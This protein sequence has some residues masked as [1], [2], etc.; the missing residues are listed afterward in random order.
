MSRRVALPFLIY[1]IIFFSIGGYEK[2]SG[3]SIVFMISIISL[4]LIYVFQ[5]QIDMTWWKRHPPLLSPKLK[6]WLL[7][8]SAYFKQLDPVEQDRFER[9]L[10]LFIKDKTFTLKL[11]K[12]YEVEED[13]KAVIGHEF[14]RLTMQ[15]EDF[16]YEHYDQFIIY[17]HPF[18]S[19]TIRLLHSAETYYDDGVVILSR[20]QVINGFVKPLEYVNVAMLMAVAC[21]IRLYPR[22]D[23]PP[24]MDYSPEEIAEG[25]EILLQPI[26]AALGNEHVNRLDL[27]IYCFMLYPDRLRVFDASAFDRLMAIFGAPSSVI[28]LG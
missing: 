3:Y 16:M 1:V 15:Q 23:Y 8:F 20:E 6:S 17:E 19:P 21:W 24:V 26:Q 13:T 9:R 28:S 27:M 12:D 14:I 7:T 22:L 25:H 11:S 4:A 10:S 18:G 5:H 2:S